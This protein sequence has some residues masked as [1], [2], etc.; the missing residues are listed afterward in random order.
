MFP[1]IFYLSRRYGEA[2]A[3]YRRLI[4]TAPPPLFSMV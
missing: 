3:E 1:Y 2:N 4:E